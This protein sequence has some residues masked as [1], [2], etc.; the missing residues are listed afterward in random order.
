MEV[1]GQRHAPAALTP[2]RDSVPILQ[3]AGWAWVEF[4]GI[5]QAVIC[6]LLAAE[7]HLT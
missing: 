1:S 6:R 2:F 4:I 7:V 5:P 3:E